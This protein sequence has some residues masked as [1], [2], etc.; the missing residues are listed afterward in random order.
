MKN[1]LFQG[2][3]I[4]DAGRIY[5]NP[6]SLGSG[7]ANLVSAALGYERLNEYKFLNR[8]ISGN[9]IVDLL[10]R[11]KCDMI[12]LKPD[13]MSILIGVN[14]VWHELDYSNGVDSELFQTYYEIMI[15]ELKKALPELKIMI[16][17]PFL[18]K[19]PDTESKWEV[20]RCEVK[21]RAQAARNIAKKYNLTFVPLMKAF[22]DA[23]KDA[24][25]TYWSADGVHPTAAGHEI[26]KREWIKAFNTMEQQN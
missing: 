16:M 21:K 8:G 17:E 3:S 24:P 6:D 14:D 4:T 9:R 5:E 13:Y 18:L 1:I 25:S 12:N 20:F 11:I 7:Y 22:D 2:D 23:Q 15:V 26:I 10:A 19:G